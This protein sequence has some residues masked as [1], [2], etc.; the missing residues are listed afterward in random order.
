MPAHVTH[1]WADGG[2]STIAIVVFDTAVTA[3]T[4][5]AGSLTCGDDSGGTIL[6]HPS[7]FVVRWHTFPDGV[8]VG[9]GWNLVD[10][11]GL[12]F[13]GGATI[14]TPVSGVIEATPA[15]APFRRSVAPLMIRHFRR[16]R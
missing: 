10:A 6:D 8:N 16:R 7:A 15:G 12:T 4:P 14:S 5:G 3:A 13:A 11:T 1:V 2:D 9:D